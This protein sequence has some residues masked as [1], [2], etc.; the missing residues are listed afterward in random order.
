MHFTFRMKTA[1]N[2]LHALTN[3]SNFIKIF[4][5]LSDMFVTATAQVLSR[6]HELY[7]ENSDVRDGFIGPN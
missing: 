4:S 6:E 5:K 3:Y 1:S 2:A 7:T